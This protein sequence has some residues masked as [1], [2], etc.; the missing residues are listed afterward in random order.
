MVKIKICF[1]CLSVVFGFSMFI[2]GCSG[3]KQFEP[4]ADP[5]DKCF[6]ELTS[7]DPVCPAVLAPGQ[8]FKVFAVYEISSDEPMH[9]W[10]RPFT[11][12]K[13][14]PGYSAHHLIPVGGANP[15][16]GSVEMWFY[17]ERPTIV[18]HVQISVKPAASEEITKTITAAINVQWKE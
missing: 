6:L 15:R 14:T 9:I 2:G 8:K 11:N 4:A 12:G 17:F 7:T 10:A 16:Q 13:R 3:Q 5:D 1:L 18:D